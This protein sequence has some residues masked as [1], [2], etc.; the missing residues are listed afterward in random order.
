MD[1]N[2]FNRFRFLAEISTNL[3][4][5]D[6]FGQFKDHNSRTKKETRQMTHFF[7][8][9]L[10]S[11]CSLYSFLYLKILKFIFMGFPLWFILVGKIPE[12]WRWKLWDENFA[13]CN[14]GNMSRLGDSWKYMPP[15]LVPSSSKRIAKQILGIAK[16]NG[17]KYYIL[18]GFVCDVISPYNEI[19]VQS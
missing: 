4:K 3:Q 18:K 16:L 1:I 14:S 19:P 17:R 7:I 2:C 6:Y 5:K 12:F 9:S 15:I 10:S 8:Y 11:N 13:P